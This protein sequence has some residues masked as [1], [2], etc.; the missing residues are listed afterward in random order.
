MVRDPEYGIAP[1]IRPLLLEVSP[2]EADILLKPRRKALEIRG[3][4]TTRAAQT[5]FVSKS[6]CA[7]ASG[8]RKR[9]LDSSRSTRWRTAD[10]YASAGIALPANYLLPLVERIERIV[11]EAQAISLKDLALSGR[12]LIAAR[13]PP[14]KI[15][16]KILDE[17][18]EAVIEDPALN[19]RGRLIEIAFKLYDKFTGR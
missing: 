15:M 12:D 11:A 10:S 13:A 2:A 19:E 3:V 18:L 9:S 8:V 1:E 17:L 16:G 6:R 14:G 7:P 4:S 5:P